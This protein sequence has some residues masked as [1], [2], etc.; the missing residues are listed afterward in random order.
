MPYLYFLSSA[1]QKQP[2]PVWFHCNGIVIWKN[3]MDW[4]YINLTL[5]FKICG[6]G[7]L[8]NIV[9]L[10]Q[11][12]YCDFWT[13]WFATWHRRL[14]DWWAGPYKALPSVQKVEFKSQHSRSNLEQDPQTLAKSLRL[15]FILY[16][17]NI[18][19][20]FTC[21]IYSKLLVTYNNILKERNT[22][23]TVINCDY[24]LHSTCYT[25]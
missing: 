14:W 7:C 15:L 12:E 3:R 8:W 1:H 21:E 19:M 2:W 11:I 16:Y 25:M 9:D 24:V 23:M 13:W 4:Y 5:Q 6:L 22:D 18:D 10:I 20:Y 17:I